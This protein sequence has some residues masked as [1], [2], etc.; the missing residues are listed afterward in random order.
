MCSAKL[1]NKYPT[2]SNQASSPNNIFSSELFCVLIHWW[3]Q[4]PH[5]PV[6]AQKAHPWTYETFVKNFGSK[7]WN[8]FTT[9]SSP[10]TC[11][12]SVITRQHQ[13]NNSAKWQGSKCLLLMNATGKF[14]GALMPRGDY[15]VRKTKGDAGNCLRDWNRKYTS[16]N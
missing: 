10:R 16:K 11:S 12:C 5:N 8:P 13:E 9:P 15:K 2:S 6:M 14:W 7:A 1:L 4:S 3:S